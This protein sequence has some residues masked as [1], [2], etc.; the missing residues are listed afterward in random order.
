MAESSEVADPN[1]DHSS[2]EWASFPFTRNL[3]YHLGQTHS[4]DILSGKRARPILAFG[5]PMLKLSLRISNPEQIY[6]AKASSRASGD[7]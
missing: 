6:T 7:S 5:P 1:R 3:V 2:S 4:L